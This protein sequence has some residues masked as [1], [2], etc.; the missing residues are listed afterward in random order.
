MDTQEVGMPNENQ[1]AQAVETLRLVA[2]GRIVGRW[3]NVVTP[4]ELEP[5]LRA[6]PAS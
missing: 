2:D 4:E 6:L 1:A 5:S 3:D